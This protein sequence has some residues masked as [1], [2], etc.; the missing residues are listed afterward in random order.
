M[1][2]NLV[3][4][5]LDSKRILEENEVLIHEYQGYHAIHHKSSLPGIASFLILIATY[6]LYYKT[7]NWVDSFLQFKGVLL[8]AAFISMFI[9]PLYISKAIRNKILDYMYSVKAS[10][11]DNRVDQNKRR[12]EEIRTKVNNNIAYLDRHSVV[13]PDYR[14]SHTVSLFISYIQNLRADTLKEAINLYEEDVRYRQLMGELKEVQFGQF[15]LMNSID[16]VNASVRDVKR[17]MSFYYF[18]DLFRR[19]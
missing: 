19:K 17:D 7:I 8:V 2:N 12:I 3:Q 1:N 11:A 5:L 9:A 6:Y 15:Q 10:E 14:Y 13:P 18:F 16:S 4:N